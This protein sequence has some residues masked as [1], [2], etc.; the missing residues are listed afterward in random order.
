MEIYKKDLARKITVIENEIEGYE[1]ILFSLK[2]D[3]EIPVIGITG[4]PGGGKSSLINSLINEIITNEKKY[5]KGKGI[6]VLAVDPSSPFSH[7]ALLGDRLRMSGHFNHPKVFIRSI[8]ARG[9]LGG[10]S[11]KAAEIT[12]VLRSENFDFIF[13][14]TVGVGQSETEIAS[15]ADTTVV[16][17]VPESGDEV[18]ALKAGIMEI[19]D[20]LVINKSDRE[21]ADK[22][23]KAVE[24]ALHFRK[25]SEWK[26]PV[27]KT[28]ATQD[29]GIT[30]LLNKITEHNHT[31]KAIKNEELVFAKALTLIREYQ[32]RQIN[33]ADLK[34]QL[35]AEQK[36]SS[37]NIYRFISSYLSAGKS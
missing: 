4:V 16:V 15:L 34:R 2:P 18:Q 20:I 22:M 31:A 10:L 36:N 7:G 33:K 3:E 23:V 13:I 5:L 21:G 14:E 37:F 9:A 19:A 26:I 12:D 11:L 1:N 8:G 27:L 17:L 24:A 6:A 35:Q 32:I 25:P 29:S 30:A 28:I